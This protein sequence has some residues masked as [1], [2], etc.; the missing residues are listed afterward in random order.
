MDQILHLIHRAS[1]ETSVFPAVRFDCLERCKLPFFRNCFVPIGENNTLFRV[2]LAWLAGFKSLVSVL[3]G[4]NN[5]YPVT[6]Q[7]F[8]LL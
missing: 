4:V 6:S 3:K 8:L 5:N 2:L 7:P 1:V